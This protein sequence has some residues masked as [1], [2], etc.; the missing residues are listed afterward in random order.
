[1]ARLLERL[2]LRHEVGAAVDGEGPD[3]LLLAGEEGQL[4]RDLLAELAGRS[5]DD[6]LGEVGL[7]VEQIKQRQTEGGRLA[8]AGL[9]EADEVR[10]PAS[11]CGMAFS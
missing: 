5:Q 9:G 6:G 7:W 10:V 3:A 1:M 11:R 2:D 8:G 4:L